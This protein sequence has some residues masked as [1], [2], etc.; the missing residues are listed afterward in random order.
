M[1]G[2]AGKA[3]G[4]KTLTQAD[5]GATVHVRRGD[6]IVIRLPENPTT[7][8]RWAP[9]SVDDRIV[10]LISSEFAPPTGGGVGAGGAVSMVFEARAPG[11]GG[12]RL[13]RWRDWEGEASVRDRYAIQIV[14]GTDQ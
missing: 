3:V 6:R 13:K 8:Y 14:V 1:S 4:E 5:N 2:S 11:D 9:D 12:V 10:S 7:G